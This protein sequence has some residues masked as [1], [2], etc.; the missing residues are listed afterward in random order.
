MLLSMYSWRSRSF[1]SLHCD[2]AELLFHNDALRMVTLLA[3]LA[4]WWGIYRSSAD[5]LYKGPA[6]Q[7]ADG[8]FSLSWTSSWTNNRLAG[9]LKLPD[10][11]QTPLLHMPT[12]HKCISINAKNCVQL[13][14]LR[15]WLSFKDLKLLSQCVFCT[16]GWRHIATLE[17]RHVWFGGNRPCFHGKILIKG[18]K[19]VHEMIISWVMKN[20]SWSVP[21]IESI[22]MLLFVF[23]YKY[24]YLILQWINYEPISQKLFHWNH[25]P[26]GN[27]FPSYSVRIWRQSQLWFHGAN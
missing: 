19:G 18:I 23:E 25:K 7:R 17:C 4:L 13:T 16:P 12:V 9:V 24:W 3:L 5:S 1:Y 14:Q 21:L 11:H 20:N 10:A 6:I 22:F 27:I 2:C 26:D 8:I 15:R